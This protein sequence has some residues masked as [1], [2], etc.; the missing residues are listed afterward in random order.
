MYIAQTPHDSEVY[1]QPSFVMEQSIVSPYHNMDVVEFCM[2]LPLWRRLALD[3]KKLPILEKHLIQKLALRH[4]PRDIVY[5]KKA[6][7]VSF[8]RTNRLERCTQPADGD[9]RHRAKA[10]SR[11][12]RCRNALSL[13]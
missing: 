13:A 3:G 9:L 1:N 10:A 8:K 6:F 7:V 12:F 11:T 4:L 5:R 2:G